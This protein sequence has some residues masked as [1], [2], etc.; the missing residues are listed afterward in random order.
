MEPHSSKTDP[1]PLARYEKDLSLTA[2]VIWCYSLHMFILR[3][4]KLKNKLFS[5]VEIEVPQ[6]CSFIVRTTGCSLSEV[7]DMDA[8]GNPVFSPAP[9]SDAFAVEME[10]YITSPVFCQVTHSATFTH[11]I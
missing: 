11:I 4:L 1:R 8:D 5:Q 7:T 2:L 3:K 9:N 10:R 6:A